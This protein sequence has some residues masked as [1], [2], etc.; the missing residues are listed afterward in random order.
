M[1]AVHTC[2]LDAS[3]KVHFCLYGNTLD[4][5]GDWFLVV[6]VQ[7]HL[8]RG[9][10]NQN[11]ACNGH[12]QKEPQEDSVENLSYE[13]PVLYHL[14]K[15]KRCFP[16]KMPHNCSEFISRHLKR[17]IFRFTELTFQNTP[18]ISPTIQ[19]QILSRDSLTGPQT[20]PVSSL[21]G[22]FPQH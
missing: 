14:R 2:Q 15:R 5:S 17:I 18:N 10:E 21:G 3:C 4:W 1:D 7:P 9:G 13:F 20:Q 19:A 22:H 12:N 8:Q 6:T 16:F 11:R